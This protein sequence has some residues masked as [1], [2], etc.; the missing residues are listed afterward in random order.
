MP[1]LATNAGCGAASRRRSAPLS[2]KL[3]CVTTGQFPK[4]LS[5]L[6]S[7]V[8]TCGRKCVDTTLTV[9]DSLSRIYLD[10]GEQHQYLRRI[11]GEEANRLAKM[12]IG[13]DARRR[14]DPIREWYEL[15]V[16]NAPPNQGS[17]RPS[18]PFRGRRAGA[19]RMFGDGAEAHAACLS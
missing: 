3:S 7:P 10:Q 13:I 5:F 4:R 6:E 9:E 1:T 17:Y 8:R 12:T 14:D 11:I 18:D 16:D 19:R 2:W 15:A